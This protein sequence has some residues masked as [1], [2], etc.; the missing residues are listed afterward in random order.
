M[1]NE[2]ESDRAMVMNLES[3][4][5][6]VDGVGYD[7]TETE[8]PLKFEKPAVKIMFQVAAAALAREG[9]R[10]PLRRTARPPPAAHRGRGRGLRLGPPRA[11]PGDRP[12]LHHCSP[13]LGR[14][15]PQRRAR[16]RA[17]PSLTR[18]LPARE[19]PRPGPD[20]ESGPSVTGRGPLPAG[21]KAR[22]TARFHSDL[23]P[24]GRPQ[25]PGTLPPYPEGRPCPRLEQSS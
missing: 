11:R 5:F 24:G 2:L 19:G 10:A 18:G 23:G 4:K 3:F 7:E 21:R 20:S 14:A 9:V 1:S 25:H 15:G 17:W 12:N 13:G 6:G 16:C 8:P 22:A